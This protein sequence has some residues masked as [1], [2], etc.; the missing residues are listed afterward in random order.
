M[1]LTPAT[2]RKTMQLDILQLNSLIFLTTSNTPILSSFILSANGN[3][4]TSFV[5]ISTLITDFYPPGQAYVASTVQSTMYNILNYPNITSSISYKGNSGLL[6]MS[7]LTN[8]LILPNN[9]NALFSSFQYNF[10]SITKYLNPNGSSKM[11]IDYYP[12]FTFS[13][14]MEP[15]SISSVTLYPEGNSSIKNLISLSSHLVYTSANSN[16]P[17]IKSGIQQYIPITSAYPYGVSSFINP[18]ILSNT[19]VTPMRFELDTN[20]VSSNLNFGFVHYIS[21]GIGSLKS[22]GGNDVFR[23]GLDRTT[24]NINN[25][26]GDKNTLFITINNSGNQF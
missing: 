7:T 12:S 16:V 23:S 11:F 8:N 20:V 6:T 24:L 10:S 18:R 19:Y 5:P 13:P 3:G 2:A 4:T 1:A 25:N 17:V 15:S 9:G 26:V 22:S 14:V 21:D